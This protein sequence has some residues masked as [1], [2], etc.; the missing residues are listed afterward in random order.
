MNTRTP[1][2]PPKGTPSPRYVVVGDVTDHVFSSY[3][4]AL[5]HAAWLKW[6]F[7]YDPSEQPYVVA[8]TSTGKR[9]RI[10]GGAK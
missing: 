3:S 10:G 7:A 8:I 2:T 4:S 1:P 5:A 9:V 6:F